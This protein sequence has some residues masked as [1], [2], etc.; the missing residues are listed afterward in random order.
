MLFYPNKLQEITLSFDGDIPRTYVRV[1]DRDINRVVFR[2]KDYFALSNMDTIWYRGSG[3]IEMTMS[4]Y[5]ICELIKMD[6]ANHRRSD[7]WKLLFEDEMIFAKKILYPYYTFPNGILKF[8]KVLGGSI[9]DIHISYRGYSRTIS[10]KFL[11]KTLS[12]MCDDEVLN[13]NDF[14][15]IAESVEE[16]VGML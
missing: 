11:Y 12:D 14:N 1:L 15:K 5:Q 7:Q 13:M 16:Y 3:L 9:G 6:N 4:G 2:D 10:E 8:E